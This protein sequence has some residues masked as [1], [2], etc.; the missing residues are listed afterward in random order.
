MYKSKY[1]LGCCFF[2]SACTI[3]ENIPDD[4]HSNEGDLFTRPVP[5]ANPRN[6][7][8]YFFNYRLT[9]FAPD[10]EPLIKETSG[11]AL[12]F[13]EAAFWEHNAYTSCAVGFMTKLPA[14]SIVEYGETVAYGNAT[15]QSESYYYLHLH[16]IKGLEAGKTYHYR[17]V[18]Q[19]HDGAT[20]SSADHTFTTKKLTADIIRIP[21]DMEGNA[22]YTLTQADA[23]YVLTRDLTV[24]TLAI[25]IKAHNVELDLD[26]HTIIYDDGPPKV[27]G[28]RWNDYA[29]NEEASF[30]IRAGL[31]NFTNFRILNGTIKQGRNGG[32]G[33]I[34]C[35]FNPLFLNHM[36]N[37]YNEVAGVTVDYYGDSVGGMV[38]GDGNIHHNVLYDR[39]SVIDDRHMAVRAIS[40]GKKTQNVFAFNSLRRFRHRGVDSS[41]RVDHNEL[42]SDSFDTNSFAIGPSDGA[43]VS[44]NKIFGMGY[45][46]I[47]IGWGN[48]IHVKGNLI[49]M[50]SFAPTRRSE[51]YDRNSA[52]AGMRITNY[53]RSTLENMLFEDN[54]IVLKAEDG[55]TGARGIWS[56]NS[57]YSK[58][59][60]YRR[61][62]IKVE[63]M[64]GNLKNP[65]DGAKVSNLSI[66][67]Y[68]NNNVNNALAAVTFSGSTVNEEGVAIADPIIFEDNRL[69][70]NVN[71]LMM[72]EGYGICNSVWMYRTKLEKIEH[73]SEFFRPIRLGF[74][75]WD[76][77]NNRMV[78]TE[79]PG[80]SE[81]EMT[82]FFYGGT[83]RMEMR[84]GKSKTLTVKKRNG[85]PG[86][87]LQ[88]ILSALPNDNHTQTLQTNG[89]GDV[90]FDLL[91][92]R[93]YKYG[94]SQ[95]HNGVSGT[96]SRTD[97]RQYTFS[98]AGYKPLSLSF[99]QL[100]NSHILT[101]EE[102]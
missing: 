85:S 96:P 45:N 12:M 5:I 57:P 58:D 81:R 32:T 28:S 22:P 64:P 41:G 9:N 95:E 43:Q 3:T 36:G 30:G 35:G 98:A 1:V 101:L 88:I 15:T 86:A 20:I 14:I 90:T 10:T 44:N 74:W 54:V 27:I 79:H 46:P 62:I 19:D 76:T 24:P 87:N 78:D 25:N 55:C 21:E 51:E 6:E 94:N 13:D 31:W 59:I 33:F 56:T 100:E 40:A 83:G 65:E 50:R 75:Y 52:V 70:G 4:D 73:D 99:A 93:H 42:Y 91:T 82:P 34:G 11:D 18:A 61:N 77:W 66:A 48:N 29:Y 53:D 39:G 72:G 23:K 71:L 89:S 92:V 2:L 17:F 7:D 8:E 68:Y 84:Y 37:T 49:Y 69:I 97:Y 80:I 63:A 26:G 16:Y 102:Q 47:G 38:T 60:V 67:P